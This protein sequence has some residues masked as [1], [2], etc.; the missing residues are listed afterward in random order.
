MNA[1]YR[2]EPVAE[3]AGADVADALAREA[4]WESLE[5]TRRL[6]VIAQDFLSIGNDVGAAYG[7]RCIIGEVR[8]AASAFRGISPGGGA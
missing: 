6:C 5:K 2:A 7:I 3:P 4:A 8:H 1:P